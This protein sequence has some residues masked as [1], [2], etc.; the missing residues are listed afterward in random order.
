MVDNEVYTY[1]QIN[2]EN[3]VQKQIITR[4]TNGEQEGATSLAEGTTLL[5]RAYRR[6]EL[7][8]KSFRPQ[9][10]KPKGAAVLL[11]AANVMRIVNF[12]YLRG[13]NV[14]AMPKIS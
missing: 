11:Y 10:L 4:N 2:E 6:P 5:V 7:S 1:T 8:P 9:E 14:P 12:R 3:A 13:P